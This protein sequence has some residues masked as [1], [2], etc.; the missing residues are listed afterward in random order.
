MVRMP[1]MAL[2]IHDDRA[3]AK[4]VQDALP[5]SFNGF[6][7]VECNA[8]NLVNLCSQYCAERNITS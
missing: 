2:L 7:I 6:F 3:K 5:S 8:A 4:I 1:Q